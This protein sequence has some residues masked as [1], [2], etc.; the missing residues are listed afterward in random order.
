MKILLLPALIAVLATRSVAQIPVTDL[1][2]LGQ[3]IIQYAAMV[4][5]ISNQ[6]TQI[7]NQVQQIKQ[8]E[9]QMK[10]L[11]DMATIKDLVGFPELKLDLTLPTKV[12]GWAESLPAVNGSGLFGDSRGGIFREIRGEFPGFNGVAIARDPAIYKRAHAVTTNV[13]NFKEVQGDVYT[14]RE[15]LR[16]AIAL[17]SESVRLAETDAAAKK[18]ESVL[19]AQYSQLSS[20]D[21]EVT[22]SA[23][24]IQ[25]KAAE[26]TA[27]ADAQDEA[28]AEARRWLAQQE[29]GKLATAFKP[30]Y[31]CMLE[32]VTE[33]KFAR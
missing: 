20:L 15:E 19:N 18:Q 6:A 10:R 5:Q 9:T 8:L 22:L 7:S 28:D 21:A 24:E 17:T 25:V 26:S 31:G 30:Y 23:A 27:M 1:A 12:K 4:E 33:K 3:S 11:G 32:Y 13:N 14:R 2:N 29:S 16:K